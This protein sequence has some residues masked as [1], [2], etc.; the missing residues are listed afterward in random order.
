MQQLASGLKFLKDQNIMHRDLKPAN[1]LIE[2]AVKPGKDIVLKIA[3][4]GFARVIEDRDMAQTL[5]G[6]PL[7]MAP[8]ILRYKPYDSAAE[9]WSVGAILFEIVSGRPPFPATNQPELLKMIDRAG[10]GL[11][12][13]SKLRRKGIPQPSKECVELI[14]GLLRP[15]PKDRFTFAEFYQ[16]PFLRMQEEEK[17]KQESYVQQKLSSKLD[18]GA[19]RKSH[20]IGEQD[21]H[22]EKAEEHAHDVVERQ[23]GTGIEQARTTPVRI[24]PSR[25]SLAIEEEKESGNSMRSGPSDGDDYVVVDTTVPG[26]VSQHISRPQRNRDPKRDTMS[27]M[28]TMDG[29]HDGNRASSSNQGRETKLCITSSVLNYPDAVEAFKRARV[30]AALGERNERS[31]CFLESLQLYLEAVKLFHG[32]LDDIKLRHREGNATREVNQKIKQLKSWALQMSRLYIEKARNLTS[33]IASNE[34]IRSCPQRLIYTQAVKMAKDAACD[35]I[36]GSNKLAKDKYK[37]ALRLSDQLS[38]EKGI[39]SHDQ[40]ILQRFKKEFKARIEDIDR[41]I[42]PPASSITQSYRVRNGY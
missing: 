26:V 19:A 22:T 23:V 37:E 4:F 31:Q 14:E 38:I 24:A 1:L 2:S 5:C 39:D 30:V 15:N 17:A 34:S 21:R 16:S 25:L 11:E 7:Y 8:E 42:A 9:L 36:V 12:V 20:D 28:N 40:E 41:R 27:K 18:K 33:F 32:I 6:T 3:D 13:G 35:E 29:A 10:K